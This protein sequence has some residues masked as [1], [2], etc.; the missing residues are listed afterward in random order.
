MPV[1][2]GY[3]TYLHIR[4]LDPDLP[5]LLASGYSEEGLASQAIKAGARQVHPEAI[6]ASG[7]AE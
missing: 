7:N 3:T 4:S 2:S 1:M 6:P 5:V